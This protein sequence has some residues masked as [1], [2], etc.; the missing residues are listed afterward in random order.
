M[1]TIVLFLPAILCVAAMYACM[2]MMG[3][4]HEEKTD[5]ASDHDIARLREE[6]D[7]L[8]HDLDEARGAS[9][10]TG[11]PSERRP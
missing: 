7:R 3:H 10:T 1:R 4:G 11:S 9:A 6:V 5:Q 8:R 2:R